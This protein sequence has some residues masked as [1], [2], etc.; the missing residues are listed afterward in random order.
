MEG[1]TLNSEDHER[2]ASP[3]RRRDP[4]AGRPKPALDVLREGNLGATLQR[5]RRL[6]ILQDRV[7]SALPPDLAAHCRVVG[8]DGG[9]LRLLVSNSMRATQLRYRTRQ[10]IDALAGDAPAR[11]EAAAPRADALREPVRDVSFSVRSLPDAGPASGRS[12]R[13]LGISPTA[14]QLIEE[15]AQAESDPTLREALLR[16]ARRRR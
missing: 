3:R 12:R 2:K 9:H 8:L 14:A 15:A 5:A 7:A 13:P 6:Q 16:L 1:G 4:G 11:N 10:L